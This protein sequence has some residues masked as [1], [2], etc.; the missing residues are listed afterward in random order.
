MCTGL[1]IIFGVMRVINFAQGDFMM[2]GMYLAYYL[3]VGLERRCAA[4]PVCRAGRGGDPGRA[5]AVRRR[6]SHPSL[7]D[8]QRD[9]RARRR[10][11]RGGA[12]RAAD[13]HAR[14]GADPAERRPDPVRLDA[15]LDPHAR[16]RRAP[17]SSGRS[18]AT[19]SR[20]FV[21]KARGLAALVSIAVAVR[22]LPVHRA[23]AARQV[24]ARGRRQSAGRDLH[25]HRRRSRAPHRF[26]HRH[27]RHGDR[28]RPAWPPTIR[29]S[30]MSGSSSSS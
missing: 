3:F 20:C 4:R 29:S 1:A 26:R 11:G 18:G 12:L 2:L 23:H 7:P 14:R 9:R 5:G 19:T 27:R 28:R 30:P 22:P 21:N 17:G 25:G 10:P 6:R 15:G 13:P 8:L 16:C 24:P